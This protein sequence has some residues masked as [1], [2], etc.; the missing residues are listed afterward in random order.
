MFAFWSV[1]RGPGHLAKR[2]PTSF[3][4]V[5]PSWRSGGALYGSQIDRELLRRPG[6]ARWHSGLWAR[7]SSSSS[8]SCT[9]GTEATRWRPP[10][11]ASP[12][13]C[14]GDNEI[15]LYFAEW[16]FGQ[17][18][19]RGGARS[20]Q[21]NGSGQR[22]AAVA[23]RLRAS[24]AQRSAGTMPG[25]TTR[26]SAVVLQQLWI[27]GLW[28]LLVAA[29]VGR[30]TRALTMVAT[31]GLRPGNRQRFLRLAEAVAGGDAAR[32]G[33][34][35]DDAALGPRAAQP[36]GG[37]LIAALCGLAMLA[38]GASVFGVIPLAAIAAYRGL[39][40]LRW[41]GVALAVGARP[42]GTVVGVPEIRRPSR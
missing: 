12:T 40:S 29:R 38:H 16:F 33:G 2:F 13:R 11:R 4:S 34:A 37:G 9:V 17:R 5:R 18:P 19:R 26:C 22:P 6:D 3:S 39:P 42:D 20:T 31:A 41:A 25:S 10:A 7:G 15:P 14:P 35:G 21:G 36:R 28:A 30:L 24:P 23:D 27:V 32:R 1:L 8:A